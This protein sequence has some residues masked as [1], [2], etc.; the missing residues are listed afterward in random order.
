MPMKKNDRTGPS[1]I[2]KVGEDNRRYA[3]DLLAENK[4]LRFLVASLDNERRQLV[5]KVQLTHHLLREHDAMREVVSALEQEKLRLQ[6]QLQ[7]LREEQVRQEKDRELLRRQLTD[8]ETQNQRFS[9]GYVEVEKRNNNLMNLYVASYRLHG[10]LD[11]QEVLGTIQ[12]IVANLVGCEEQ[13]IFE[14]DPAG[15]ELRLV[16][17]VGIDRAAYSSVV[18]GEGV[19]GRTALDGQ[20][21]VAG[22][23]Q[24][25][26]SA[27]AGEASIT[28]CIPLK[29]NGRVTG[30]IALFRLLPQKQSL[31]EVDHELFDLLATHAATAL[32]CT[33]LHAEPGTHAQAGS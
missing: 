20:A 32:Y 9:E 33:K 17:S 1:Y 7:K 10:T 3:Q 11:R 25:G 15:S 28:A 27:G 14:V 4:K 19:I 16:A 31:E 12:E 18:L 30:A 24:C 29:L 23:N 13:A 26:D 22:E 6:E 21:F 2:L 5:E 8:I